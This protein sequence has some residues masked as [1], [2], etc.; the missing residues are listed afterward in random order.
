MSTIEAVTEL[1]DLTNICSTFPERPE[2]EVQRENMISTLLAL[3]KS[4]MEMVVVEGDEG[5]G[6]TTLLAPFAR[7]PSSL[8]FSLFVRA[9]SH[10]AWDPIM[11]AENLHEQIQFAL[12]NIQ[13]RKHE[14]ADIPS[15]L[16]TSITELQRKANFEKTPYYFIVDGLEEI[17][18]EASAA[19]E[20]IIECLP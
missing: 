10:Y 14:E 18:P 12:G 7:P 1:V 4:N 19:V 13:F 2:H 3:L 6:K 8:S 16:R 20:Q 17:P 15:L 5:G 11:V 9:A